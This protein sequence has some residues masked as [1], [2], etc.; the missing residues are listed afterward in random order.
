MYPT[1]HEAE[2]KCP[3]GHIY[4]AAASPFEAVGQ[5]R[6][7]H[8]YEE[9]VAANVPNGVQVSDARPFRFG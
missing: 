7:P 1:P 8:C 3:K 4:T 2:Y 5:T 6:C 9:W